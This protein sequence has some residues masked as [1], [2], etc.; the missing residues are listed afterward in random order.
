MSVAVG[1]L[2]HAE[3]PGQIVEA[4]R[5]ALKPGGTMFVW[6]YGHE[7]NGAYLA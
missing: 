2:H 6:L 1:V 7:G 3:N 4:S 5:R